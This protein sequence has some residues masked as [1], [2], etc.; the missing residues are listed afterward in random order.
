V[1]EVQ[2]GDIIVGGVNFGT[3]SSRPGARSIYNAGIRALLAESINGLMLR[4]SVNFGLPAMQCP[5]ITDAFEEGD[6]AEINF[7]TGEV[8]N[9]RTGQVIQAQPLP[10]MLMDI[11]DAGGIEPLL[12]KE[13]YLPAKV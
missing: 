6:T 7:V 5:G 3:G 10:P 9:Q 11:I 4:N 2:E 13:G 12:R 8:K 1:D